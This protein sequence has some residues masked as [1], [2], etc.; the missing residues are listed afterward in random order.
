MG[1]DEIFLQ[2]SA[3]RAGF[4]ITPCLLYWHY[5]ITPSLC[6]SCL[7]ITAFLF[8]LGAFC[9]SFLFQVSIRDFTIDCFSTRNWSLGRWTIQSKAKN[10]QTS[11]RSLRT[12]LMHCTG[13]SSFPSSA[14]NQTHAPMWLTA[15]RCWRM[16]VGLFFV[17]FFCLS[18][19]V[20]ST[21]LMWD[22]GICSQQ[23]ELTHRIH[24]DWL[25]FLLMLYCA[26][27]RQ[28]LSQVKTENE[29]VM[30]MWND[31]SPL[32]TKSRGGEKRKII[33]TRCDI[34]VELNTPLWL[35]APN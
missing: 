23:W 17:F 10:L 28:N 21:A 20:F 30:L 6:F 35:Y 33:K 14:A 1:A 27:K 29:I 9:G 32:E 16:W 22:T 2:N 26:G 3:E 24:S 34:R 18:I 5:V 12:A 25:L 13:R 31:R 11:S 4:N 19:F 8:I 7:H 15:E